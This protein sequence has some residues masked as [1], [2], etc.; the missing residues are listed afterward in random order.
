MELRFLADEGQLLT[1]DE[2]D[3]HV[4]SGSI[5]YDSLSQRKGKSGRRAR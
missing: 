4:E 5:L 1:D 3:R 2:F